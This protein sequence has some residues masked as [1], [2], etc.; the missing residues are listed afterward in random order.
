M[1]HAARTDLDML[2]AAVYLLIEGRGSWSVDALLMRH[3]P[4]Q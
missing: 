2:L 4:N 1:L 3:T